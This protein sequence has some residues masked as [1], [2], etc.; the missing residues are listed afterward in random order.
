MLFIV[1]LRLNWQGGTSWRI[2]YPVDRNIA[3]SDKD[4]YRVSD[5]STIGATKPLYADCPLALGHIA[6][7][8]DS[9]LDGGGDSGVLVES[10]SHPKP[11]RG[12]I[13][14]GVT[15]LVLLWQLQYT[16]SSSILFLQWW[17]Q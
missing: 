11:L 4:S 3:H 17:I 13:R 9:I 8:I 7:R 5:L 2:R 14:L 1:R 15:P 10:S 6:S 12:S 16:Y